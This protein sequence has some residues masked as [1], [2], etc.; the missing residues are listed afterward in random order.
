MDRVVLELGTFVE[1][2]TKEMAFSKGTIIIEGHTSLGEVEL[3]VSLV[4]LGTLVE[5]LS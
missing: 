3:G 1:T 4:E 5:V 2:R